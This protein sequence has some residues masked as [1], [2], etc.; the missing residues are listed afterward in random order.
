MTLLYIEIGLLAPVAGS[1]ADN[2]SEIGAQLGV[3]FTFTGKIIVQ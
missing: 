2:D 3:C 1:T